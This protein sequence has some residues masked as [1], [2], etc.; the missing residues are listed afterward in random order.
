MCCQKPRDLQS[1]Q[2]GIVGYL[3]SG[4]AFSVMALLLLTSWKGRLLGGL[5]VLAVITNVAWSGLLAY[6]LYDQP[7]DFGQDSFI[8]WLRFTLWIVFLLKLLDLLQAG[9]SVRQSIARRWMPAVALSTLLVTLG[10]TLYLE[11]FALEMWA[12][13]KTYYHSIINLSLSLVGLMLTEQLFRNSRLE[14]RWSVKYLFLGLATLFGYDFLLYADATL[15]KTLDENLWLARGYVSSIAVPLLAIAVAR[16]RQWSVDIFVSRAL[17]FYS[18]SLIAAG[19]YLLVMAAAG[20]YI[21]RY[22]GDWGDVFFTVF[23]FVAFILL[24]LL[25]FSDT[26]RAY[27]KLNLSKHF[28]RY[29]YDYREEWLKLTEKMS[30]SAVGSELHKVVIRSLADIMACS[31]GMLWLREEAIGYVCMAQ[32]NIDAPTHM[33]PLNDPLMKKLRDQR[34]IIDI[35]AYRKKDVQENGEEIPNWLYEMKKPWLLIPLMHQEELQGFVILN[36]SRVDREI[37]WE[38]R[39]LLNAASFHVASYLAFWKASEALKQG[40][41]FAAFNRLSSFVVHDLKNLIMQLSL[42]VRNSEKFRDN[43]EFYQDAFKTV[44]KAT[45]KMQRLLEQLAKGRFELQKPEV[46]VLEHVLEQVVSEFSGYRPAPKLDSSLADE[47]VVASRDRF[48][49]VLGHLIRNAQEAT[50]DDGQVT[51][52]AEQLN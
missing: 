15:F 31:G 45:E 8:E 9:F 2:I 21:Q 7:Y 24:V 5:L 44:R 36:K 39:D 20:Y 52:R 30:Q 28:F 33:F 17:V 10:L 37:N 47:R 18:T 11:Y 19:L 49:S 12:V 16:N 48:V 22:G 42:V 25:L 23:M 1:V 41:Q 3:F 4:A 35:Q 6:E 43:P 14:K 46:L 13:K 40:D 50:A 27:I 38:D 51:V 34:E 32:R 29:K 26:L